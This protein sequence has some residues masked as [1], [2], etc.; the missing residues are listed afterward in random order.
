MSCY[1][2]ALGLETFDDTIEDTSNILVSRI[3][4]DINDTSNYVLS[5]NDIFVKRI[6]NTSNYVLAT[7][8]T[9][10]GRIENTSNY[11]LST[12]NI[13]TRRIDN[14]SN[15]VLATSNILA[16]RIDNT[17]NYAD[18]LAFRIKE[19]E[20]T[21]ASPGDVN[22]GIPA[23]PATGGVATAAAI[24]AATAACIVNGVSAITMINNLKDKVDLN[25]GYSSNYVKITSNIL[26]NR[27]I[28]E[29]L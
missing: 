4:T 5:T 13:L 10:I 3:A 14:T 18:R 19:L 11:V 24:T 26:V 21:E 15:Y 2:G 6:E 9:F 16:R 25:D 29:D 17:S 23:M 28:A 1:I 20:G 22:L 8:N 27:M 12:S 7:S